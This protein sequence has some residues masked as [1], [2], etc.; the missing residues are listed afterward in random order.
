MIF[1]NLWALEGLKAN[2]LKASYPVA[3]LYH[4]CKYSEYFKVLISY[5]YTIR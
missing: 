3:L 2:F 5:N 4:F 1:K